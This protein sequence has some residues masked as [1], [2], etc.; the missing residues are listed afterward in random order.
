MKK[1]GLALVAGLALGLVGCLASD[2]DE[3]DS[4]DTVDS[5]VGRDDK[6]PSK[7]DDVSDD[8][9]DDTSDDTDDN[10][11]DPSGN[12]DD[13]TDEPSDD[14][15]TDEDTTDTT[16]D[17]VTDDTDDQGP[18]GADAGSGKATEDDGGSTVPNEPSPPPPLEL[19][20]ECT[21]SSA[22][23]MPTSCTTQYSCPAASVYGS[24]TENG[25]HWNCS[26]QDSTHTLSTSLAG[27]TG[28]EACEAISAACLMY[29][30]LT[31][32]G[33]TECT[34]Y[35]QSTTTTACDDTLECRTSV[36]L[37]GGISAST[38][39][40]NAS[41]CTSDGAGGWNCSCSFGAVSATYLLN[42]SDTAPCELSLS[43]CE[44]PDDLTFEG[45]E[46]CQTLTSSASELRC[47]ISQKCTSVADV[48]DGI[49]ATRSLNRSTSCLPD[50][51]TWDC[52][53]Q[54]TGALPYSFAVA[55]ETAPLDTCLVASSFCGTLENVTLDESVSCETL[56][57]TASAASCEARLNCQ[58]GREVEGVLVSRDQ[59]MSTVC[60]QGTDSSY[61]CQCVTNGESMDFVLDGEATPFETCSAAVERCED[62]LG[63]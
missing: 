1:I 61:E 36:D 59:T 2:D 57:Q 54:N 16:D 21:Q 22:S 37:G 45:D 32:D 14:S 18:V 52:Q 29:E 60:A 47:D 50:G 56:S 5:G 42:G 25:D 26:C 53:C 38:T 3:K 39:E 8:T 48:S 17:A 33:D 30:S 19:P 43:L 35:S 7:Q 31:Y 40:Y 63:P 15:T 62:W 12:T 10:S 9:T 28:I 44:S 34:P 58:L 27:V 13:T 55:P 41:S 11:D 4:K 49:T 24:C 51:D 46:A 20:A 23:V 6:S